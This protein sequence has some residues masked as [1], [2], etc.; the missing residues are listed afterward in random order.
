[1]QNITQLDIPEFVIFILDRLK[2]AGYE[3]YIVGGAVRDACMKRAIDDWDV[4]TSA[5]PEEIKEIFRHNKYFALKHNTVT[6]VNPDIQVQVTAYKGEKQSLE[7]DLSHRDF[8]INSMAFD[9]DNNLIIDPHK[10]RLD[11][12]GKTIRTTGSPA[13]RFREDPLRLLRAVRLANSLKFKIAKET[14]Q[15][16][17]EK[18]FLLPSTA[19]ERIRD[20]LLKILIC[21]TPSYGFNLMVKT[22]LLKQFLPEL[23]EG[24]GK[25]QNTYH[26]HT[27]FKHIMETVSRVKPVPLLRLAALFHDIAK[28]R[29]MK[30]TGGVQTFYG[31]EEAGA[32]MAG[33]IMDRLR[34]SHIMIGK[35]T[36]LIRHHMINYNSEWTDG[37]V[38]RLIRRVG[39]NNITD[40]LQVHRADLLAHGLHDNRLVLLSEL[41]ARVEELTQRPVFT[42]SSELAIDG[43]K[44]MELYKIPPGPEVGKTLKKLLEKVIDKP[45]LNNTKA[46]LSILDEMKRA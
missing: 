5:Q 17:T 22:G 38:R 13:E 26:R 19:P 34:F 28:P 2:K 42:K 12:A 41:E 45:E 40:L 46:L 7:H 27:I 14:L 24:Y 33:E 11:I 18:A 16:I 4:V 36:N 39:I 44:V 23:L 15:V 10:G 35:V 31:H 43:H 8:T 21:S 29:V 1:M 25:R 37:A 20:E 32:L 6:L 30:E 3:A 9:P